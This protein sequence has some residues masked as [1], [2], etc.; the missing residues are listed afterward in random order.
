MLFTSLVF[1]FLFLPVVLLGF[2]LVPP[3][4]KK[5]FLFLAS[6]VFYAWGGVSFVSVLI[7]SILLN[8]LFGILIGRSST[9]RFRK[10]W[11]V[12][13]IMLNILG[14]VIFKYTAFLETNF[15][16]LIS[17][18]K[19]NPI[20]VN[21]VFLPLGISFFTFRAVTYLLSVNR[22]ETPPQK[23]II[24]LGLY[25]GFFPVVIAGPIDRYRIIEPQLTNPRFDAVLFASGVRR[26]ALGLA[27]KIIIALPLGET[28]DYIFN[29]PG[30][31]LNAPI[32]W[33][34]AISYMLQVYYD[35]SGYTDMAIGLGR[36]FGFR[37]SENFNFPYTSRSIR[38]FWTRWHI[39]LSTWLRDY[40]FLPFAYSISRK[41]KQEKYFGIRVD[42]IIYAAA[43]LLTF[44][45]CGFW[46]GAAWTFITWGLL[47]GFL[48]IFERS[49]I[50]KK[51]NKWPAIIGRI[52]TMFF[53]LMAWILFRSGD[54]KSAI[55]YYGLMFGFKHG[56]ARGGIFFSYLNREFILMFILAVAGCTRLFDMA[57]D[58][59]QA[60]IIQ[61]GRPGISIVYH[62][63]NILS[64]AFILFVLLYSQMTI[65][66]NTL[67]AF[68]YFRF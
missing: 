12:L 9:P 49:R 55:D 56:I 5:P 6:L 66:S 54:L 43:I 19:L 65:L 14:L 44:F 68:I 11:I 24:D 40:V 46:H 39:T 37:F 38:D 64:L 62:L 1:L 28:A 30:S 31:S 45:I 33:L 41:L 48:L 4:L 29:N 15:N 57:R 60:C 25:L 36:M 35:F 13:G 34:G 53:I 23:N 8:Y 27:K 61:K 42:N 51:L 63:Y 50:G 58:K 52:Y 21:T 3:R 10:F 59:M 22:K 17:V 26:F 7:G 67:R 16:I 47:F 18:F 20:V 2:L 32:A